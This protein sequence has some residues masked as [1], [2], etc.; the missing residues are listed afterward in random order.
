MSGSRST[1]DIEAEVRRL[2]A[3]HAAIAPRGFDAQRQRNYLHALV[4]EL[5]DEHLIASLLASL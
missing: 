2:M 5:L 1:E 4:D 3:S